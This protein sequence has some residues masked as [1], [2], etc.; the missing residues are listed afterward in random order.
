MSLTL[1]DEHLKELGRLLFSRSDVESAA[2]VVC[3]R[4]VGGGH[5]RLLSRAVLPVEAPH[6]LRR[7]ADRLSISDESFVPIV[8]RVRAEGGALVLAHSHPEGPLAFSAQDDAEEERFFRAVQR[9]APGGSHG[10]LVLTAPDTLVGRLWGPDGRPTP[11]ERVTVVGERLRLLAG[12][13]RGVS[14]IFDRQVRAFGPDV[15]RVLEQLVIGVVGVGGTGSAVFEQ[16]LRLGVGHI[17]VI[18]DDRFDPTNVNRVHGSRLS[19]VG[20]PKVD[21]AERTAREVGL[22]GRVTAINGSILDASVARQLRRCDVVFGCTDR[23][24]PRL[25]LS[26]I[27]TRY[28]TP[29]IDVGA[30][31]DSQDG[32]IRSL[33]GRVTT[34]IPG[35]ACLLCRGQVTPEGL[36]AEALAPDERRRLAA[37]GYV[38]GLDAAAPAVVPFTTAV[39]SLGIAELLQR[40]TGFMGAR[41]STETLV[42]FDLPKLATNKA[43]SIPTC[44]CA[45]A[46]TWGRGDE[47]PFLGLTWRPEASKP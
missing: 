26:R 4:S 23:Q 15:Q 8:K 27:A 41:G 39:A 22:P 28:L 43:A 32:A 35:A 45:D 12:D 44:D 16:L 1:R 6:Y 10:S 5:E 14:P 46:S 42:R 37:E 11:L 40:L 31:V 24:F 17:L 33:A 2:Y 36:R 18:D 30:L 13:H 38:R 19:D 29:V 21:I 25:I 20:L 7:E 3:G 9:R 34:L 47:E